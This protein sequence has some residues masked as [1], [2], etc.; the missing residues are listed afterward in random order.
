[1]PLDMIW[2]ETMVET[3]HTLTNLT[4]NC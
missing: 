3:L 1:M 2:V 4:S